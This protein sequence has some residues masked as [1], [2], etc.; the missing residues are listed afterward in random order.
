MTEPEGGKPGPTEPD[1]APVGP[2]ETVAP[3]LLHD[4]PLTADGHDLGEPGHPLAQ[5]SPF[6][7]GFFG[8]VGVIVALALKE[9]V[10][11]ASSVI[12]LVSVA[13]F[14]AVGLNPAVEWLMGKGL[15]R[16]FAVLVVF[17]LLLTVL[18]LFGFSIV[19]VIGEQVEAM[20]DAAPELIRDLQNTRWVRELDER[21]GLLD[22]A[23]AQIQS[24]G[25]GTQIAGGALGVGLAVVGA[26]V[27][28]FFV[29]VLT[30]YFLST[31]PRIKRSMYSL[32]PASRRERVARLGDAILRQVGSYVSG[33]AVV[34]LCA[35]TSSLIFFLVVGLSE[36]AVALAFVVLLLDLVPMIGATIAMVLVSAIGLAVDPR[37]GLACVIFFLAYQQLENYVIYPRVM[38]SSVDVPGAVVVI[39]VLAGGTLLGVIGALLAIPIAAGVLLVVREVVIRRQDAR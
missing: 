34:A 30:L 19:P 22:R 35:G 37:I 12:L 26:L 2:P 18:V 5:H 14:L 4:Y 10:V 33:A 38:A 17:V 13:M 36:Y 27:N 25:F 11:A 21:F 6:Y 1:E 32:I 16:A 7:I 29:S 39:A 15:R 31:L 9:L 24:E 20:I 28:V 23:Y 3:D 8:A